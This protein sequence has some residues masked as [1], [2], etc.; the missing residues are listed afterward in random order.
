MVL[1]CK[2]SLYLLLMNKVLNNLLIGHQIK[3]NH[4]SRVYKLVILDFIGNG[5][6]EFNMMRINFKKK[7]QKMIIYLDSL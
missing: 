1:Y 3:I 2:I 6:V 4:W 7:Y 5:K